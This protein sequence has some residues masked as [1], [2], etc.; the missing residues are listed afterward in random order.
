[1]LVACASSG[2]R[3][4]KECLHCQVIIEVDGTKAGKPFALALVCD[5]HV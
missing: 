5:P 1:V 2:F 4:V 3:E